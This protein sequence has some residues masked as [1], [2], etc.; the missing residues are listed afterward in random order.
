MAQLRILEHARCDE[1]Y[2]HRLAVRSLISGAGQ[3]V[4]DYCLDHGEERLESLS[5]FEDQEQATSPALKSAAH[6]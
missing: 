2:C 3:P 6:G 4:G 5:A 1:K